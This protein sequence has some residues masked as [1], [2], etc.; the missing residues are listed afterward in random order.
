[1]QLTDLDGDGDVDVLLTNGD[2]LD[3]SGDQEHGKAGPEHLLMP[4]H[5]VSWLENAGAL[6]FTHHSIAPLYGAHRAQAADLDGDGDM[7]VVAS[8]YMPLA[9]EETV[10]GPYRT[11]SLIWLERRSGAEWTR[12]TLSTMD[13]EIPT[14]DLGDLDGDG[15]VDIVTG[16]LFLARLRADQRDVSLTLWES[17]LKPVKPEAPAPP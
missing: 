12:H 17:R 5:G 11:E 15:D 4:Y 7:D 3:L 2:T 6:R 9:P 10:T 8:S 13:V 14:L 16:H 1:M